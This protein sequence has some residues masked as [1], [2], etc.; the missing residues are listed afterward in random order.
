[1]LRN[2]DRRWNGVD[3]SIVLRQRT[4]PVAGLDAAE[5]ED[6][7]KFQI[8]CLSCRD[9]HIC[10]QYPQLACQQLSDAPKAQHQTPT[11]QQGSFQAFQNHLDC[12]LRRGGGIGHC[13]FFASEIVD[14]L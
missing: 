6:T 10:A 11:P 7:R 8:L 5:A 2:D 14:K 3:D 12:S 13:Q 4:C 9:G 1:M